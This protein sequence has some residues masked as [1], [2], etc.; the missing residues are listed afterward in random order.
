M[1]GITAY[2]APD[3]GCDIDVG[4]PGFKISGAERNKKLGAICNK[5]F[6]MHNQ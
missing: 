1:L 5:L 4:G 2:K 3:L 6:G